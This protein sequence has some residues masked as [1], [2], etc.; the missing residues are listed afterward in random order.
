MNAVPRKG[1][2]S[3]TYCDAGRHGACVHM[4]LLAFATSPMP[5]R[6]DSHSE[7]M[8]G[9][10]PSSRF[11]R[12]MRP[13]AADERSALSHLDSRR[14]SR[15]CRSDYLSGLC[16]PHELALSYSHK[17]SNHVDK[18]PNQIYL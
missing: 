8:Y 1:R 6:F 12:L 3:L 7:H 10:K 14:V 17:T 13:H 16:G 11:L 15:C 9:R 2:D 5:A 18:I 4:F